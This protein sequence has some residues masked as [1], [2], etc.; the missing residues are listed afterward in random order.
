LTRRARGPRRSPRRASSLDVV[1]LRNFDYPEALLFDCDGVLCETER[2]GHRTTFNATFAER[3]L[4]HE[5]SVEKYGELLEIGGGKERMTHYFN[6]V[7]TEEP[8]ATQFPEDDER[9][10]DFIKSLHLRKTELFLE[11]VKDGKLPLRPGVKRLVREA[12]ENG[13]KVAVCSTSNEAAV[14]GIVETMLPEFADRI[15][16]FAGDI[17][18]K[19]KP[20][21]DVYNLAAETLGVDPARCV[22]IEDTRIGTLAGKAAGMRVCVTKSIYSRDEDFSSADAVFDRV[23]DEGDEQF[24]FHELTT[25]GAYW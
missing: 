4:D 21:P 25:P 1:A 16:V 15:P 5:W 13:A 20:A 12:L 6:S 19:K 14:R 23:G 3:G 2:D 17:V 10:A 8:F 24:S 11:I 7:P 22:V 18:P 9:R